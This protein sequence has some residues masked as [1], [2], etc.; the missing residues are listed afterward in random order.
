NYNNWMRDQVEHTGKAFLGLTLNCAH[1]HDHKY[2]PITQEE[3]FKF[4]AFFEPLELRHD[5][6]PGEPD[7]GPFK[8]YVYA[9]SYGP[10]SSGL[11]PVS[12]EKLDA[13]TFM[14]VKGDERNRMEGRPPV[15]PGAPAAL[16]GDRLRIE[17]VQLPA[18]ASYPGLKPFVQQEERARR[19]QALAAAR[20]GL[21]AARRH[22]E[23]GQ[24]R[25][26]ALEA[27]TLDCPAK[28]PRVLDARQAW[29]AALR[30]APAAVQAAEARLA[31][32]EADLEAITAR[33][34]ADNA[35]YGRVPG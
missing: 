29:A 28:E 31:T 1:C 26:A 7:P 32:A 13:P 20:T 30:D 5:R 16:G 14:Y 17:P 4:R 10:I 15:T 19:E 34:A 9:Q 22:L 12:D 24:Q 11:I 25:A 3:Y 33:V 23:E 18:T 2:D 8:K 27:D 21:A 6:V 35:K